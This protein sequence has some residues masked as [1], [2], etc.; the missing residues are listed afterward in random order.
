MSAALKVEH[1]EFPEP[2]VPATEPRCVTCAAALWARLSE[3]RDRE[4]L[5]FAVCVESSSWGGRGRRRRPTQERT[6]IAFKSGG[7]VRVFDPG[8]PA[9]ALRAVQGAHDLARYFEE[10]AGF[11]YVV[12]R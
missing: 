1:T 2:P 7:T 12:V 10:A 4:Q 8:A 6:V 11:S 9:G 3:L 5:P